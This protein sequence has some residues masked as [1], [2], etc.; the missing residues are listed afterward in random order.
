MIKIDLKKWREYEFVKGPSGMVHPSYD[1]RQ[2][3]PPVRVHVRAES[4]PSR[5]LPES[6]VA[7][8]PRF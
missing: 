7:H 5:G 4:T 2:R 8:G 1:L 6:F 3:P